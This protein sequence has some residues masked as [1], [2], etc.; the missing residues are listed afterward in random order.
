[1]DKFI[2]YY[3]GVAS[4]YSLPFLSVW[5][6]YVGQGI[7]SMFGLCDFPEGAFYT[8]VFIIY[9]KFSYFSKFHVGLFLS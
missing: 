9:Y 3:Y 6:T 7:L 8:L 1:M 2:F 4:S 5:A